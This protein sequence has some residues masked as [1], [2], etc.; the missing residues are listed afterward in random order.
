MTTWPC[1]TGVVTCSCTRTGGGL[2]AA[3]RRGHG[4]RPAGRSS[5]ATGACLDFCDEDNA[6]FRAGHRDPGRAARHR[7]VLHR[8]LVGRTRRRRSRSDPPSASSTSP[9]LEGSGEAGRGASSRTSPGRRRRRRRVNGCGPGRTGPSQLTLTA[10]PHVDPPAGRVASCE[11]V[12]SGLQLRQRRSA[13]CVS[14]GPSVPC[15]QR[16]SPES[17]SPGSSS[18]AGQSTAVSSEMIARSSSLA[19]RRMSPKQAGARGRRTA[20]SPWRRLGLAQRSSA[21]GRWR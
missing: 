15:A 5:P 7:P 6:L 19:T 10:R 12:A 8:L 17:A 11:L 2:R 14:A 20:R 1:S 18:S 3:D 16:G 9:V 13:R 21:G 4:Q